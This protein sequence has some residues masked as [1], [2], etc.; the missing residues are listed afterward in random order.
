MSQLVQELLVC[1]GQ[2]ATALLLRGERKRWGL[3]Q[4]KGGRG[5]GREGEG[6]RREGGR[7][8]VREKGRREQEVRGTDLRGWRMGIQL[9]Q[10]SPVGDV[11]MQFLN[12]GR[13][14]G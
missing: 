12:R 5:E 1:V 11:G 4:W 9:Q 2:E 7:E 6:E 13:E 10:S 3:G 8:G 14:G